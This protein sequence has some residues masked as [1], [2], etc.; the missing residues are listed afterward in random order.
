[1]IQFIMFFSF[2]IRSKSTFNLRCRSFSYFHFKSINITNW[3]ITNIS[4]WFR[5]IIKFIFFVDFRLIYISFITWYRSFIDITELLILETTAVGS[6]V[7]LI[8]IVNWNWKFFKLILFYLIVGSGILKLGLVNIDNLIVFLKY[9][10]LLII[11]FD[12]RLCVHEFLD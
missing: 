6:R 4:Y 9:I 8:L 12:Y 7:L 11:K 5:I 10:N 3:S 1:M 2:I